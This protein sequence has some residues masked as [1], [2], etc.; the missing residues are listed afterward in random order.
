MD[1]GG[2]SY[3]RLCEG[4]RVW[5]ARSRSHAGVWGPRFE[6][7]SSLLFAPC[8]ASQSRLLPRRLSQPTHHAHLPNISP[9]APS[10]KHMRSRCFR[11][12][13]SHIPYRSL[14]SPVYL[15]QPPLP[16]DPIE[17]LPGRDLA[18]WILQTCQGRNPSCKSS[19]EINRRRSVLAPLSAH[20]GLAFILASI[21]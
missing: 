17:A 6:T 11:P 18:A 1:V 2:C 21:G 15:G 8:P 12:P 19:N 7:R 10:P 20:I 16:P 3:M 4:H 13:P 9:L 14:H 5:Y